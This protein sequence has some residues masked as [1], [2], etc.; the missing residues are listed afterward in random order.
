MSP[1][2]IEIVC[3]RGVDVLE[4]DLSKDKLQLE[5]LE[6]VCTDATRTEDPGGDATRRF[7]YVVT[8]YK[9]DTPST[10]I[11]PLSVRYYAT[12]PGQRLEDTP[13]AGSVDGAG[14]RDRV[15]QHAAGRRRHPSRCDDARPSSR[16]P[17]P[18]RA[19]A[20]GG[21]RRW[22]SLSIA[23][24]VI[25]G[26]ALLTRRRRR[27]P[28]RSA[29][30]VRR[31]QERASLEAVRALS[32]EAPDGRR[33]RI[34]RRST[35]WSVSICMTRTGV[36]GPEPDPGRSRV[37]RCRPLVAARS[38]RIVASLLAPCERARYGPPSSLP[39][40]DACRDALAQ[41]ES[42]LAMR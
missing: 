29:R 20:A 35:N 1:T 6:V 32:M 5:G 31:E 23:P 39:S 18:V 38:A 14:R 41:T 42:L 33:E 30:Q 36:A 25:W 7:N 28:G 34:R 3:P 15:A 8:S 9:L 16:A 10:T 27:T 19:G 22:S 21:P 24:A 17:A 4:D 37:P 11:A 40:A 2:P 12:R 13:P 26:T